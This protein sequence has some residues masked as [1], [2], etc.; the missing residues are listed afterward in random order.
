MG[1]ILDSR[2]SVT[3]G[4]RRHK[5]ISDAPMPPCD[6]ATS[7]A[8][9]RSIA[10]GAASGISQRFMTMWFAVLL[11][12]AAAMAWLLLPLWRGSGGVE[13]SLADFDRAV[14]RGQL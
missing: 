6:N 3:N 11:L 1:D 10:F 14:F 12:T 8:C 13:P 5:G 9:A 2:A 7:K 4:S